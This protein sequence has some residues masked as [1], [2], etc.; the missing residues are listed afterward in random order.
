[1]MRKYNLI[2][3]CLFVAALSISCG[4]HSGNKTLLFKDY[5][6]LKIGF[7]TQNFQKAMPNTVENL[8]E[9]I[10]YAYNEGYQFIE[11]R[12]DKAKLTK[13]E[14]ILLSET[15]KKKNIE[16]IYEIHKNPLDTGY[17][18]VFERGLANAILFPN[19]GIIRTIVS[20]S[21]FDANPDK[22]GWTA[23][24]LAQLV[25]ITDS[26]TILAKSNN[27]RFVVENLNE[28]FFGD[29]VTY[30]GLADFFAGSKNTGLQFDLSNPFRNS[31]RCQADPDRVID[32]LPSIGNRW[33]ITHLKTN[34]N[35]EPQP[36]LTDNP[37][38]IE[39]IV[40]AAWRQ[41]ARYLALELAPESD[42]I[43][44]YENHTKSIQFLRG[45]GILKK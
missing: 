16:V 8:N 10:N 25:K 19:P 13:E 27:I 20:K 15:A 28:P 5:H 9:L 21:E 12:D 31:S 39:K 14:C 42:K 37:L 43:K 32:Y 6:D 18:S 17:F 23:Q 41:N 7:S 36:V 30:F 35:G 26:C 1:M 11:L 33:I 2:L 29:Q 22:K 34:I 40:N 4:T 44:C 38:S 3:F 45:K 24:E